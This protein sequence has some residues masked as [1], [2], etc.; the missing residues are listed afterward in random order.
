MKPNV[1]LL[2]W[3]LLS[4]STLLSAQANLNAIPDSLEEEKTYQLK[5]VEK[6]PA[7][8]GGKQ[9]LLK[10]R[11]KNLKYPAKALEEHVQGTVT[12]TIVIEKDGSLSSIKIKKGIGSD[13]DEAVV[14]WLKNMPKWNPGEREG[15]PVR[16]H[17]TISVVFKLNTH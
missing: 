3:G 4:T 5:E 9:E 14:K 2:F 13:C 12:A 10:Y 15:E 17:G 1:I 7:F 8:P 16:V 6:A 11:K